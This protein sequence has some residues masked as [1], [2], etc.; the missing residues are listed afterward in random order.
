MTSSTLHAPRISTILS[1]NDVH[2][3]VES[4]CGLWRALSDQRAPHTL[5]CDA[6][7]FFEGTLFY[8]QFGG[9]PELDV[10][11]TL[12]DF[13]CPGNH[14]FGLLRT[15]AFASCVVLCLNVLDAHNGPLFQTHHLFET[16]LGTFALTAVICEQAFE[17]IP[18]HERDGLTCVDP[19]SALDR[20]L[21]S[22]EDAV[23]GVVVMSHSGLE[24][25][26]ALMPSHPTLKLVLSAH[27]HQELHAQRRDALLCVKAPHH[28]R[29]YVR[30]ALNLKG[31]SATVVAVEPQAQT[32]TLPDSL[33][34]LRDALDLY[35]QRA[36]DVLG[37]WDGV[38]GAGDVREQVT[39]SLLDVARAHGPAGV[40]VG[41]LNTTCMREVPG[42]GTVTASALG[43]MLPFANTFVYGT[44]RPGEYRAAMRALRATMP[45]HV[46]EDRFAPSHAYVQSIQS[47]SDVCV[48][49]TSHLWAN[50]FEPHGGSSPSTWMLVRECFI[51]HVLTPQ[52]KNDKESP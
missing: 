12:V 21:A 47:P 1:I 51:E 22:L 13:A 43:R 8:Q 29:G 30:V 52:P 26:L 25:D 48:L 50:I 20:L 39:R 34:G 46:I 28:A 10:M 37:S 14:G 23:D 17:T 42:P 19:I 35:N 24:R 5:I 38:A 11:D 31:L 18:I 2:S 33:A 40:D 15:H 36:S 41:V 4:S 3:H 45:E 27:C 7:D 9:L 49:T 44:L 32:D 6:G 16:P